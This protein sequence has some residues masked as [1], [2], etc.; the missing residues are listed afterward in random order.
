MSDMGPGRGKPRPY[1]ICGVNGVNNEDGGSGTWMRAWA[2][3]WNQ[4]GG[5][6]MK[7]G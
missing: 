1:N 5:L 4:D 7:T 3:V 6:G 2:R